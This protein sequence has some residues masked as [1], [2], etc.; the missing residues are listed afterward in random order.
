MSLDDLPADVLSRVLESTDLKTLRSSRAGS[1]ALA[2]ASRR[3]VRSEAFRSEA[4]NLSA[5]RTAVWRESPPA[6]RMLVAHDSLV[7]IIAVAI[8]G[9]LLASVSSTGLGGDQL[10][11]WDLRSGDSSA[12]VL[13]APAR[14]V[15][16]RGRLVGTGL[17]NGAIHLSRTCVSAAGRFLSHLVNMCP[18]SAHGGLD[19]GALCWPEPAVLVSGGM[20]RSLRVWRLEANVSA[21]ASA[22]AANG[23]GGGGGRASILAPSAEQLLAHRRPVTVL[24]AVRSARGAAGSASGE[25]AATTRA[26]EPSA[27]FLS[28][29]HDGDIHV[30]ALSVAGA[31]TLSATLTAG[32]KVLSLALDPLGHVAAACASG[33]Q[34][35]DVRKARR[36][37]GGGGGSRV[38]SS[39]AA[40]CVAS[41][42]SGVL[43]ATAAGGEGRG[44]ERE[45]CTWDVREPARPRRLARW[46]QMA[47]M[48]CAEGADG[49][50][51]CGGSEGRVYVWQLPAELRGTPGGTISG[52]A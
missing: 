50:V 18:P 7:N 49:V 47:S 40:G 17:A 32:E 3:A 11:L 13:P 23:G 35:W 16:V 51:V 6:A 5:L 4:Q 42:G 12:L 15:A 34:F 41:G 25:E 31:P 39:F 33:L 43:L 29:S 22:A 28:A 48:R 37:G 10:K 2:D 52:G 38:R 8:D 19:V 36:I 9:D 14:S 27:R 1:R 21:A 46:T 24:R 26:D 45:V 44:R 30:W 20:D